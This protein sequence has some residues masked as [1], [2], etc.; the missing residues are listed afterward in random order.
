MTDP[1][2]DRLR[3][4]FADRAAQVAAD[5]DPSAFVERSVGRTRVGVP[6]V[7][8]AVA[9]VAL[10][11]GG[12]FL[13]GISVAASSSTS[14][15]STT[16]P[17]RA[18]APLASGAAA[19]GSSPGADV[20]G[21]SAAVALTPLFTRTSGSGVDI[22]AYTSPVEAVGGCT[23]DSPCPPIGVVPGHVPC[24]TGSMCAQPV[25]TP[26]ATAGDGAGSS[27][28]ST[29]GSAGS[30]A[31][32]SAGGTGSDPG[33]IPVTTVPQQATGCSQLTLEL[34]TD[35]AVASTAFAAPTAGALA[36][37][38]VRLVDTGSFGEAEGGPVGWVAAVVS[39]DVASVRLVSSSGAVLDAMTP[40]SGV[41]VLAATGAVAL[42]GTS[43]VG[44]DAGGATLAT[45]PADQFASSAV[46]GCSAPSP[47][48]P[49]TTPG[50][51]TTT[52]T[53]PTTSTVVPS[54]VVPSSVLPASGPA[55]RSS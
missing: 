10:L 52:T 47:G 33:G 5:P 49:A 13:T 27:G 4:H 19:S 51:P 45:G 18:A 2:E 1:L 42:A 15:T 26:M 50:S 37:K 40:S 29:S 36:P 46:P 30:G 54:T 43:V 6:L 41:V 25:T 44:L 3:S 24:P 9:V 31:G 14:T 20:G 23:S 28:G 16:A 17:G 48:P 55:T 12:G 32:G 34:S 7:A 39:G 38:T 11:T 53:G 35:R 22:R 21:G 8:G